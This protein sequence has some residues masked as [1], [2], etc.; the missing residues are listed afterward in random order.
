M[1][2][3]ILGIFA[4]IALTVSVSTVPANAIPVSATDYDTLATGAL[5]AG[6]LSNSFVVGSG[7]TTMGTLDSNVYYNG[8]L[9][10]YEFTVTPSVN[11]VSEVNTGFNVFGFNSVAGYSFTDATASAAG[12]F[13]IE[14]DTDG[15]LDFTTTV[16][17]Q[18]DSGEAVT[19]FYQS[20]IAPTV[21]KYNAINADVGTAQGY[22][23]LPEPATL[24]LMGAGLLGLGIFGRKR[25]K[26]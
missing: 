10:T 4:M 9:Y 13:S 1:K 24:L 22:A 19:F 15:T 5:F 8:S 20:T 16:E 21:K 6:P 12:G 2:K 3:K 25:I 7:P 18:F 11:N 26:A 23:P 14:L 17:G